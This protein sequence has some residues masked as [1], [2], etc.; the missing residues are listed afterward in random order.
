MKLVVYKHPTNFLVALPKGK[1]ILWILDLQKSAWQSPEYRQFDFWLGDWDV[2]SPD[3]P[4]VGANLVTSEQDGCLLIE[5]WTASTGGETG[6]SFNYY[7]VRTRNGISFTWI[8]PAMQA[9]SPRAKTH[10][11]IQANRFRSQRIPSV[12]CNLRFSSRSGRIP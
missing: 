6:T 10:C 4:S 9:I 3:G 11:L 5:H 2:Y 12:V 8:T 7:D 1:P